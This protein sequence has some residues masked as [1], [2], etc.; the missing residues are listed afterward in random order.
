MRCPSCGESNQ[1]EQR[2]C[3][4]CGTRLAPAAVPTTLA[5]GRYEVRRLL[6]E[7]G[8]KRVYLATDTRLERDV[9]IALV[10]TE[11]LDEAGLARVRGEA[12][13]M[14]RLGAHPHVVTVFDV[15]DEHGQ[16]FIVSQYMPGGSVDDLLQRAE[17]H[18]LPIDQTLR[19]ASELCRALGHAHERG[20]VHRDVK[21]S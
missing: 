15:G 5:G 2:F 8:K 9:A 1:P 18:R 3:G 13:A 20:I 10:K 11:G 17:H 7:G 16:P 12:R 14:G 21:P 6:G 4:H 19:I